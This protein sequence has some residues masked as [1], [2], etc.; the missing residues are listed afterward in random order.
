MTNNF[1]EQIKRYLLGTFSTREGNFGYK[2]LMHPN[3][4]CESEKTHEQLK[5]TGLIYIENERKE[6]VASIHPKRG[7]TF[8]ALVTD[9]SVMEECRMWKFTINTENVRVCAVDPKTTKKGIAV[10]GKMYLK[11]VG[12]GVE[13]EIF[14][15]DSY[16]NKCH[17]ELENQRVNWNRI[18]AEITNVKIDEQ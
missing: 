4:C 5:M 10:L 13:D 2:P 7:I 6:A 14:Y 8:V 1:V 15:F 16:D 18:L 9:D 11:N 12:E 3:G 17:I